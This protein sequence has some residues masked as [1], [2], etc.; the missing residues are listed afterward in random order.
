MEPFGLFQILQS[1][2]SGNTAA[3]PAKQE[4]PPENTGEPAEE[5]APRE[6]ENASLEKDERSHSAI[7][8]FMEAHDARSKRI[9]K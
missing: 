5:K 4:Q 8:Q 2:L 6:L 3:A 7:L 1:L 9:K